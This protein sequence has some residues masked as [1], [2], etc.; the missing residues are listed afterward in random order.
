[1]KKFL[2]SVGF[3]SAILLVQGCQKETLPDGNLESGGLYNAKANTTALTTTMRCDNIGFENASGLLSQVYSDGGLGPIAMTSFNSRF[4]AEPKA[5]MVFDSGNPHMEDVDLGTP[6]EGYGGPGVGWGGSVGEPKT[7]NAVPLGNIIIIQNFDYQAPNDDDDAPSQITFDF[8]SL[9]KVTVKT[10][11][12]IDAET[13][14]RTSYGGEAE[15]GTIKLYTHKGG[16]E[17]YSATVPNTNQNGVLVIPLATDPTVGTANVGY[18]EIN[19]IGSMGFDNLTFCAQSRYSPC[20]YTQGYWKN[21]P[22]AWPVNSMMLGTVNYSKE[23]LIN[24]LKEPVRGN[25]LISLAHQ[26][27]AAK[28]NVY[29]GANSSAVSAYIT[30]A[31]NMIGSRVVPPV[32]QGTLAP[33]VTSSLT[34]KLD[35]YNNGIIGPGHCK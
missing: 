29:N 24:I 2:Y 31:D 25:G 4:P 18:M 16:T 8:S 30:A 33:A 12:V 26:L 19:L 11:T 13:L 20:T 10:I 35:Q 15:S 1:M 32:G 27:I 28:L 34:S 14:P 5:A 7:T 9:G 3:A 22:E 23:Q 6:N 17:L 21:H